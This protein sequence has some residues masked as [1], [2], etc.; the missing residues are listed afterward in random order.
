MHVDAQN[1]PIQLLLRFAG[2]LLS[3]LL[4]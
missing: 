4:R 2:Q 3:R 1:L